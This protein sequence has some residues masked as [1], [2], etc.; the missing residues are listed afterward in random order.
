MEDPHET[1]HAFRLSAWNPKKPPLR[2]QLT[3]R[4]RSS[5]SF[6]PAR[7]Q[8]KKASS[9]LLLGCSSD[10]KELIY[11]MENMVSME[12]KKA[13]AKAVAERMIEHGFHGFFQELEAQG[14]DVG[15]AL[16]DPWKPISLVKAISWYARVV[17]QASGEYIEGNA[18]ED[19]LMEFSSQTTL[20]VLLVYAG[21]AAF[22]H[23]K[24]KLLQAAL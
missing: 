6:F 22:Q 11:R 17:Q 18:Q 8:I 5:E 1:Q 13:E 12:A 15:A 10:A 21:Y 7:D 9:K 16:V 3:T 2:E 23:Q 20:Q 24:F 19:S 14:V 4:Y